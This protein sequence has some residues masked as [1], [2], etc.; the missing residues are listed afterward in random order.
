MKSSRR[1]LLRL[2]APILIC[3]A[4]AFAQ[5][6]LK[7]TLYDLG[8]MGGMASEATGINNNGKIT[9]FID[10]VDG[11]RDC[12]LLTL[13]VGVVKW[14]SNLQPPPPWQP[15]WC[16][17]TAINQNGEVVGVITVQSGTWYG[18][19]GFHRTASGTISDLLPVYGTDK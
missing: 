4:T 5:A 17:P 12:F 10:N 16:S 11:H 9:G 14:T 8:V 15:N 7:Y 3:S 2:V 18:I 6:T 19:H 13:F 1:S